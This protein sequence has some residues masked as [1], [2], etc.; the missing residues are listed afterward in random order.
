MTPQAALDV[1]MTFMSLVA[2]FALS[3]AA[4]SVF[5]CADEVHRAQSPLCP[6]VRLLR[7]A[8]RFSFG[9]SLRSDRVTML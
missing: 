9:Q 7:R 4:Q 3:E 1:T 8:E 2:P 5:D 6:I